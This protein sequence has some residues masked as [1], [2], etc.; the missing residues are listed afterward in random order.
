MKPLTTIASALI[1]GATLL[2][3]IGTAPAPKPEATAPAWYAFKDAFANVAG[4]STTV[5]MFEQ[6]GAR[7]QTSE[8]QYTFHKP[9]SATIRVVKGANAGATI[10]WNGGDTVVA[11]RGSGFMAM[12]KK[13]FA[14]HDPMMT[15]IRGSSIDQLSFTAIL[16]HSQATLGEISEGT[17]PTILDTPTEAV[18]L[19]P[20]SPE[21]DAGLTN[22]TADISSISNLPVRLLGYQG[23]T[24]VRQIDFSNVELLH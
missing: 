8:L 12:F 11:Y 23:T 10:E 5:T 19:V 20:S 22:E 15:T 4:Y 1:L 9:S 6:N 21:N 18:T 3:V 7:V 17:G 14:L 2:F 24:L 16:A 13:T